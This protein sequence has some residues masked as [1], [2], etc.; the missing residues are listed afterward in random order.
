MLF[1]GSPAYADML[2][3]RGVVPKD[4]YDLSALE[5]VMLAGAP[6]SPEVY[7]WF[8]R[9]VKRDL[10]LHVGSGGTDVCAGFTGGAPT[11]PTYPGEDQDRKLRGAARACNDAGETGGDARG[12]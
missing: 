6:V 5:C 8:Y 7:A 2:A 3:K 4:K 11:L 12:G 1:G 10:W 9:N